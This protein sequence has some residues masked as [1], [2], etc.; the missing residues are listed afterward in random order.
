MCL[1][2]RQYNSSERIN[3][4]VWKT[5]I[6]QKQMTEIMEDLDECVSNG[7]YTDGEYLALSKEI[8]SE[9]EKYGK[10]EKLFTRIQENLT[11]YPRLLLSEFDGDVDEVLSFL[12]HKATGIP[13][14]RPSYTTGPRPKWRRWVEQGFFTKEQVVTELMRVKFGDTMVENVMED[15]GWERND[16]KKGGWELTNELGI[17]LDGVFKNT[18]MYAQAREEGHYDIKEL[19]GL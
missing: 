5:K 16:G 9:Y 7:K 6:I 8:Q 18:E 2:P 4:S 1:T 14:P 10:L 17:Q 19:F 3:H 11:E 13:V 12:S 15:E